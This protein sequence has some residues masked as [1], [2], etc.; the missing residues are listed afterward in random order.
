MA[1]FAVEAEQGVALL[2]IGGLGAAEDAGI[3]ALPAADL[4]LDG[5]EAEIIGF[6]AVEL[7]DAFTVRGICEF[8]AENFRVFLRLLEPVAGVFTVATPVAST[9]LESVAAAPCR[10]AVNDS[11]AALTNFTW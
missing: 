4:R 3:M 2:G 1:G 11:S 8:Q 5:R 6:G 7:D 9:G 10:R